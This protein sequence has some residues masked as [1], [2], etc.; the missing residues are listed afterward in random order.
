MAT[1]GRLHLYDPKTGRWSQPKP[2]AP[3]LWLTPERKKHMVDLFY[4]SAYKALIVHTESLGEL[5]MARALR[6]MSP[7]EVADMMAAGGH[8]LPGGFCVFGDAGCQIERHHYDNFLRE[9]IE[10]WKA[11]DR[12]ERNLA[13]KAD[14]RNLHHGDAGRFGRPFDPV[15]RE[16]FMADRPAYY[17]EGLGVN[18][19]TVKAAAKIRLP[20]T[21]IRFFVDVSQPVK[22]LSK[23]KRRKI[24]RYGAATPVAKFTTIHDKC[25]AAIRGF[26]KK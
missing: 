15:A 11:D 24:R 1:R 13:W 25:E 26:W 8:T 7:T 22:K 3:P 18:A 20:S 4:K 5:E 10:E 9:L 19:M 21:N 14:E 16:V 12:E 23:N 2:K 6:R 17:L